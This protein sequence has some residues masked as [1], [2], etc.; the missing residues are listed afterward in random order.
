MLLF[1]NENQLLDIAQR[2]KNQNVAIERLLARMAVKILFYHVRSRFKKDCNV[3]PD[4]LLKKLKCFNYANKNKKTKG[5]A[6]PA[7]ANFQPRAAKVNLPYLIIKTPVSAIVI[8]ESP[9]ISE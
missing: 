5:K 3:Q 1:T 4:R 7:N 9:K 8:S 2:I 6:I